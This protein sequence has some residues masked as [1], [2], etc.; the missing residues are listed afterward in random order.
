MTRLRRIYHNPPAWLLPA[1]L[2][3]ILTELVVLLA[4]IALGVWP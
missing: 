3:G 2:G 4:L 1:A